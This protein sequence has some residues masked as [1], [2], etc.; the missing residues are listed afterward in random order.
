MVRSFATGIVGE[1]EAGNT[2]TVDATVNPTE[3][4]EWG[5]YVVINSEMTANCIAAMERTVSGG[6]MLTLTGK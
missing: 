6:V 4:F 2:L 1:G 5:G 3:G